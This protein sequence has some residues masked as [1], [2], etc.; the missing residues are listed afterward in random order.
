MLVVSLAILK[1][2]RKYDKKNVFFF[3]VQDSHLFVGFLFCI[4]SNKD[5]KKSSLISVNL[6]LV[7]QTSALV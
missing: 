7:A 4:P 5:P 3:F 1:E 6:I 2:D